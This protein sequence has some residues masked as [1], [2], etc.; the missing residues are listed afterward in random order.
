MVT[1]S[2]A[3]LWDVHRGQKQ[4]RSKTRISIKRVLRAGHHLRLRAAV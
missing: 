1:D 3:L 2:N 4:Q